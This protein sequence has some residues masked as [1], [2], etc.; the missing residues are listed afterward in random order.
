M[1]S[2]EERWLVFTSIYAPL[3]S[4]RIFTLARLVLVST[5]PG[6]VFDIAVIP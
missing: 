2:I 1:L 6:M 3:S 4:S 5:N